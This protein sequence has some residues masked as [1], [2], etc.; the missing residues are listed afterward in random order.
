MGGMAITISMRGE[1]DPAQ[2]APSP[3]FSAAVEN[4]LLQ[5]T[6]CT[7]QMRKF[8]CKLALSCHVHP[9]HCQIQTAVS[10][11]SRDKSVMSFLDKLRAGAQKAAIQASAFAKEGSSKVANESRTF[12]QGFTLP[13]EA[14]K[15]AKILGSFLGTPNKPAY[16]TPC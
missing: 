6:G 15:A 7:C 2:F 14:D 8:N 12:A 3:R 16:F 13:G 1:R 5:R 4:A 11:K 10:H 9:I